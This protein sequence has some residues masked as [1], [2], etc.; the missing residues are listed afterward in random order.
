MVNGN[1]E[2]GEKL[3]VRWKTGRSVASGS[4]TD[5][6]RKVWSVLGGDSRSTTL[7][8][9]GDFHGLFIFEFD[10]DGRVASHTIEHVEQG[11]MWEKTARV[12]SVTDWLLGK[13][14]RKQEGVPGLA[15]HAWGDVEGGKR[16][17][18]KVVVVER[19]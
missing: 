3:I 12:I 13:A 11:N 17:D 16:R 4:M 1:G 18:G 2:G 19:K 10:E 7:A 5:M 6:I 9:D 8:Q 14:W 15:F